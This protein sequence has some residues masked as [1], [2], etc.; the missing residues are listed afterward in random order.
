MCQHGMI[1]G[2]GRSD[3]FSQP[4]WRPAGSRKAQH[5]MLIRAHPLS[6][7]LII[8]PHSAVLMATMVVVGSIV[9]FCSRTGSASELAAAEEEEEE[10]LAAAK[11]LRM[12]HQMEDMSPR[13]RHTYGRFFAAT[14]GNDT[15]QVRGPDEARGFDLSADALRR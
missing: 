1:R 5:S 8:A 3:L 10:A 7:R 6:P 12:E 2:R 14:V 15:Q 13:A 11:A 9:A 4:T